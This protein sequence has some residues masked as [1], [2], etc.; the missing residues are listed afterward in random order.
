MAW[1][2]FCDNIACDCTSQPLKSYFERDNQRLTLFASKRNRSYQRWCCDPKH[3]QRGNPAG[4]AHVIMGHN[5]AG[6]TMLLYA[7]HE[8][9]EI[10]SGSR[11]MTA[12]LGQNSSFKTCFIARQQQP[13]C[14]CERYHGPRGYD[15][16]VSQSRP[17]DK[18]DVPAR[19]LSAGEQ[20][21]LARVSACHNLISFLG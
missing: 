7:L 6:K 9:V 21:E 5:G 2:L 8:L 1:A 12:G 18:C 19:Q 15:G 14:L 10:A 20:Q 4:S 16:M 17:A 11:G 13:I 3:H